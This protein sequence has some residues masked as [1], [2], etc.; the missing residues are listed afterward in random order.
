MG[1]GFGFLILVAIG[2][3]HLYSVPAAVSRVR[4]V[5]VTLFKSLVLVS[6][7][8]LIGARGW[9]G[10][11]HCYAFMFRAQSIGKRMAKPSQYL[12]S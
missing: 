4:R 1:R 6:F 2:L 11:R 8:A 9:G 5:V 12:L 7:L 3:G 10:T